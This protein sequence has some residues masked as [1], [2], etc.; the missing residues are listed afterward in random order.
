MPLIVLSAIAL[1][2]DRVTATGNL[3]SNPTFVGAAPLNFDGIADERVELR[4]RSVFDD[5]EGAS[6]V[7][8]ST[9][10]MAAAGFRIPQCEG[11]GRWIRTVPRESSLSRRRVSVTVIWVRWASRSCRARFTHDDSPAPRW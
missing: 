6:G 4:I 3:G 9:W 8:S 11:L 10:P 1:D 2:R 5:V 7:A